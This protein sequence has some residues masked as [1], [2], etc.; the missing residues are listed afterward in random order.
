MIIPEGTR[1]KW[2]GLIG[3]W[4]AKDAAM[5]ETELFSFFLDGL[6]LWT[7]LLQKLSYPLQRIPVPMV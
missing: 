5:M 1:G 7:S 6:A 4:Q 2:V 3:L